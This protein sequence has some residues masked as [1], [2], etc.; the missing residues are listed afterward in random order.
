ME[1]TALA[2]EVYVLLSRLC[3]SIPDAD[4]G[5]SLVRGVLQYYEA[6]GDLRP[7]P[8]GPAW[9]AP[10][11][12]PVR[13]GETPN[14]RLKRKRVAAVDQHRQDVSRHRDE[15]ERPATPCVFSPSPSL[16]P[17]GAFRRELVRL[18]KLSCAFFFFSFAGQITGRLACT[19]MT[20][21]RRSTDR[22]GR[23]RMERGG[24]WQRRLG[25]F[26]FPSFLLCTH[27]RSSS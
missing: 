20:R 11:P 15:F 23:F 16:P 25:T 18:T 7:L 21:S 10:Q 4:F 8:A 9:K 6:L 1:P 24:S 12:S 13:E 14:E 17:F 5:H 27:Q 22:R 19:T 26:F 2:A 3:P